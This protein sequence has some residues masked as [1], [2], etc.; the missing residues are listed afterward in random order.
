MKKI[1]TKN[2]LTKPEQRRWIASI[3][4]QYGSIKSHKLSKKLFKKKLEELNKTQFEK[5]F[6]VMKKR[7][8]RK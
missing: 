6:D 3:S 8:V 2:K 4:Y 1:D 5:L 7:N